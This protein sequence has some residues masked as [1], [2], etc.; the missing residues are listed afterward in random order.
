MILIIILI[1][2]PA[3]AI[4]AEIDERPHWSLDIKGGLFIPGIDN[5]SVN[6][7]DRDTGEY[8]GSVAYK[9]LRNVEVGVE[10]V[11]IRASGK[12]T[13]LIGGQPGGHVD[14]DLFPLNVFV[15]GRAVFSEKQWLIPYV[16]GGWTRIFYKE[17]IQHQG[18]VRGSVDGYH[19]RAGIQLLLDALDPGAANSFYLDYG[20]YHTYLFLEARY[21]RAMIDTVDTP[22]R[23][24]NLGGTSWLG[25]LLFEF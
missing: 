17:E 10:G 19:G 6:Y 11:A 21:T 25:G 9:I 4:A 23:S 20:V 18:V 15:M 1:I 14:L 8:G 13:G 2:L 5:W 22:S 12:G 7:G 3:A 16:G 24:V